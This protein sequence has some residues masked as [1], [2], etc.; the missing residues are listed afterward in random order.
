MNNT[1][2]Q[3]VRNRKN[4]KVGIV[5]AVKREDNTVGFG[6]SLCAVRRGDVFNPETALSMA[7]GRAINFPHFKC[8]E[9]PNT[10][11]PFWNGMY[12]RSLKYFKGCEIG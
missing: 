2:V 1:L 11:I 4:Q 5:V 10:V 12:D 9:I 7:K 8:K 3:Y 6:Y